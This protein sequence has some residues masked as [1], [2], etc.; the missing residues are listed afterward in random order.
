MIMERPDITNMTPEQ[1]LERGYLDGYAAATRDCGSVK[2]F[3]AP[4]V[5]GMIAVGISSANMVLKGNLK[6][7]RES[8]ATK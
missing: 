7:L 2:V 3:I 5:D 6:T 4:E 1:A 8:V